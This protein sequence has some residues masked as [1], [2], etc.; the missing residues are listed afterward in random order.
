MRAV[1]FI[2]EKFR[3]SPVRG[4]GS[5]RRADCRSGCV[6]A[7]RSQRTSADGA[8]MVWRQ[9]A[10]CRHGSRGNNLHAYL[11]DGDQVECDIFVDNVLMNREVAAQMKAAV[12]ARVQCGQ[13]TGE[14][15]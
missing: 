1:R 8:I 6:L 9:R 11:P 10:I 2:W 7:A 3:D 5:G 15:R 14:L 12:F 4:G 13:R